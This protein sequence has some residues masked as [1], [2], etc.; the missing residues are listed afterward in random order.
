VR[1]AGEILRFLHG[2]LAHNIAKPVCR[3][4]ITSL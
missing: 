4:A 1:D 2:M 3:H